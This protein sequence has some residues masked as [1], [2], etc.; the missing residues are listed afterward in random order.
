M[1][2]RT[3]RIVR[4]EDKTVKLPVRGIYINKDVFKKTPEERMLLKTF[5]KN[6]KY[7]LRS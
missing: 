7:G 2:L 3:F 5:K 6:A 1:E 4:R